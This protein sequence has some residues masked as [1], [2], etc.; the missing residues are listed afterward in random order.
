LVW[1][2][3][4]VQKNM[5]ATTNLIDRRHYFCVGRSK[6][7]KAFP[8]SNQSPDHTLEAADKQQWFSTAGVDWNSVMAGCIWRVWFQNAINA[9]SKIWRV[10]YQNAINAKSK[11]SEITT[12]W[13]CTNK[14]TISLPNYDLIAQT[15]L[16]LWAKIK[17]F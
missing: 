15:I 2:R 12:P 5:D 11:I 10:W 6:N 8:L 9:K 3:S 13:C 14:V 4:L 16:I 1:N 7:I 17:I